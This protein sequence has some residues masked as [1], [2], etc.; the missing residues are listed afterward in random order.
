M[1]NPD[2]FLKYATACDQRGRRDAA[3]KAR[4][5]HALAVEAEA[6]IKAGKV[7][8]GFATMAKLQRLA[9]ELGVKL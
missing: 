4:E 7:Y 9:G 2:I 5:V 3:A 8:E 6:A 1:M